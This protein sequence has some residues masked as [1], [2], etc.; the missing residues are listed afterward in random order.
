MTDDWSGLGWNPTPGH[1]P[2]ATNLS[3]NL[4]RT[5]ATLQ[6]TYELL[7]SL[8][9]E[10]SYW[11]GEASK[12]FSKKVK[13]LPDYL[14]RAHDSLKAASG[15]ISKWSDALHDMKVKAGHYE[16]EAKAARKKAE[17]AEQDCQAARNNPDLGLADHIFDDE[18]SQVNAQHKLDA[19]QTRLDGATKTLDSANSALQDLI[20]DAERLETHHGDTAQEY[21]DAIRKHASDYAP[22]G[23]T[24]D[25]FK[26]WWD[27]HGG[28]LLTT[29]AAIA[30]IAAIFCPALA[31]LAIGLSLAA[32]AQH[33]NQYIKSGKDMWPPTSKNLGEWA[34][35]GGDVLGAVPGVGPA[36][37][38]TKAAIAGGKA[39]LGAAREAG[40]IVK[41]TATVSQ[42][43]KSGMGAFRKVAVDTALD[44]SNRVIGH[45]VEKLA[46]KLGRSKEWAMNAADT[47]Q[48][49]VTGALASPT[50]MTLDM[51][52]SHG[53]STDNASKWATVGGDGVAGAG[54]LNDPLKKVISIA[55]AL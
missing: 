40:A 39:A 34:T 16:E 48:A 15:E 25:K 55:K 50:A 37:K 12:A 49:T 46:M 36:I 30:G 54:M 47:V 18:A 29:A 35:L 21:A 27:A 2:L 19:A 13:D 14:K 10:S 26:K 52:W 5:A 22:E 6:S 1:P 53:S 45:P 42:A 23:G 41:T 4:L 9:K 32:A 7:D 24:W 31:P 43:A 38:G 28:D 8:D 33:A 3:N 51:G 44:S 20:H 11:T 17:Q